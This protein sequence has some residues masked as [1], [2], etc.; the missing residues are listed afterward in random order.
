M[1]ATFRSL[2][3]QSSIAALAPLEAVL[4]PV[5]PDAWREI[6]TCLYLQ[7]REREE[8][9][10]LDDARVAPL[11]LQLTEGLRAEIGGSQP[12]LSK[13]VGFELSQRDRQILAEFTGHNQDELAKK[14]DLTPRQIYA[15]LA[16]RIREEYERRQGRLPLE[17]GA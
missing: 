1:S 15:I 17:G 9:A 8:L 10:G 13:G 16:V 12:Y 7:L 11:A 6:A 4:D 3:A 14:Y 5:Y 2:V